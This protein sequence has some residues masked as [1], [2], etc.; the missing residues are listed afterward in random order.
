MIAGM[1]GS[2]KDG[3]TTALRD[4]VTAWSDLKTQ[5]QETAENLAVLETGIGE[6]TLEII[7]HFTN[8]VEQLNLSEE[9]KES[10]MATI[11]GFIE[12]AESLLPDV[13]TAFGKVSNAVRTA[14]FGS[15]TSTGFRDYSP[16]A[17]ASG[18]MNAKRGWNWVG[19]EGPELMWMN[20]GEVI[21]PADISSHVSA[22]STLEALPSNGRYGGGT[23]VHF[24]PSYQI[25]GSDPDR[26]EA[27][28]REHDASMRDLIVEVLED[29]RSDEERRV[30]N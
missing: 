12:G 11:T 20:G 5:Q 4:M 30:Y 27:V 17:Y 18:T 28:L 23:V 1:A 13:S 26:V 2:I 29:I 14:L 25:T 21:L 9:A 10:G 6:E 7:A 15:S 16:E 3:D 24:A 19:E 8:E 22:E